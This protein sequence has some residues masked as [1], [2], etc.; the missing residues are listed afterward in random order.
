MIPGGSAA[1]LGR[2]KLVFSLAAFPV[3]VAA[4]VFGLRLQRSVDHTLDDLSRV[5]R[6][7]ELAD[8]SLALL[9]TQ[10][11]VTNSIMADP[12]NI[13]EAPRK[14]EAFDAM[15]ASLRDLATLSDNPSIR[16]AVD[17]MRRMEDRELRP[18]DT[19]LLEM[20]AGGEADKAKRVFREEYTPVVA[21]Y[22]AKVR[23]VGEEAERDASAL[24]H[25]TRKAA[26]RALLVSLLIFLAGA[27][28]IG[29]VVK[30]VV[31]A[32]A[33][34]ERAR[35]FVTDACQVLD[36]V[37]AGEL[38]VRLEGEYGG[39]Q[40]QAQNAVNAVIGALAKVMHQAASST[41][42]V[43]HT[44]AQIAAAAQ[45][46]ARQADLQKDAVGGVNEKLGVLA[47]SARRNVEA[48]AEAVAISGNVRVCTANAIQTLSRLLEV[49][50]QIKTA[51]GNTM[52]IAATIDRLAAQTNLLALNAKVEASRAGSAGDGFAVVAQ[53]VRSLAQRSAD[54]ASSTAALVERAV[55]SAE[56][57]A[58][59]RGEVSIAIENIDRHVGRLLDSLTS[60][61]A[62]CDDQSRAV[63]LMTGL[64]GRV[65]TAAGDSR[66]TSQ[67]SAAAA[68]ELSRDVASLEDVMSGMRLDAGPEEC[69]PDPHVA[70]PLYLVRASRAARG[71]GEADG[72]VEGGREGPRM[73]RG[74]RAQHVPG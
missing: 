21:R 58:A 44:S 18:A 45:E 47:D 27:L 70:P 48:T 60:V 59:L 49:I 34:N 71:G 53:E 10:E 74:A 66:Q 29:V 42:M 17:D 24:E 67:A 20:L 14:I 7:K 56:T 19:R 13:V 69:A 43:A 26:R 15:V 50:E 62:S 23:Q 28:A 72:V 2:K 4:L 73:E 33:Q 25:A 16:A 1:R 30:L 8:R 6:V 39:L 3:L 22:S 11:A 63:D 68:R 37:Q 51:A 57:G 65:E 40:E 36:R 12:D 61:R 64:M 32:E 41:K 55:R 46:G 52:T 35:Q 31:A 9:V 5:R 38:D 54:A